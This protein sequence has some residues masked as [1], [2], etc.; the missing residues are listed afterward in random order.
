MTDIF[1][2]S[3]RREIMSRVR[4]KNTRAELIVR[5]LLHRLGF[6]FRLHRSDLPGSPDILLPKYRTAV[7]VHGCFWHGHSCP[8]GKLPVQNREFWEQKIKK[9]VQRDRAATSALREIEW[10]P[11]IVWSCRL[12][13]QVKITALGH[14]LVRMIKHH[15]HIEAKDIV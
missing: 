11:I 1:P 4:N 6:R 10:N 15:S 5:S 14:D 8:R 2:E 12:T 9:N 13:S 3:K 7:F